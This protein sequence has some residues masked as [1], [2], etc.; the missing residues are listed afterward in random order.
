MQAVS[1]QHIPSRDKIRVGIYRD[2]ATPYVDVDQTVE[3]IDKLD[4]KFGRLAIIESNKFVQLTPQRVPLI[5]ANTVNWLETFNHLNFVI[6]D[7]TIID[8]TFGGVSDSYNTVGM[9]IRR[10][11]R[12]PFVIVDT[13]Y[14]DGIFQNVVHHEAAHLFRIKDSGAY[15]DSRDHCNHP[16]CLMQPVAQPH[17]KDFC[18][19]CSEQLDERMDKLS[20]KKI[21]NFA[22]FRRLVHLIYDDTVQTVHPTE[23]PEHPPNPPY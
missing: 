2:L 1:R 4:A 3:A 9:A 18:D 14:S 11:Y 7:R 23:F 21:H 8:D 19:E 10:R 15:F 20:R 13:S 12:T 5:S 17:L 22:F 16:Q 6:T